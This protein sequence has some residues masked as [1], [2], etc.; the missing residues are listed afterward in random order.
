[1]MTTSSSVIKKLL[2]LFLVFAGLYFANI[3]DSLS[4]W[5]CLATLFLPFCKWMEKKGL[6]RGLAVTACLLVLLILIAGVGFLLGWQISGLSNDFVTL[7][8]KSIE[9]FTRIQEYIFNNL[10]ISVEKQYQY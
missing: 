4:Y 7:K 3:L 5:S 8:Q 9:A 6:H 1:M 2:I 10:G